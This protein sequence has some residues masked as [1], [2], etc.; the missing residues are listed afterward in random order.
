MS[1]DPKE[2]HNLSCLSLSVLTTRRHK[3]S[4]GT[5]NKDTRNINSTG[6]D[7]NHSFIGRMFIYPTYLQLLNIYN[8]LNQPECMLITHLLSAVSKGVISAG[9]TIMLRCA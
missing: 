6:K 5:K 3:F 4:T 9:L 7:Q 2:I 8:Q 1:H